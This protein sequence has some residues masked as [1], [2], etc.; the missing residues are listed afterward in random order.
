VLEAERT[1]LPETSGIRN[2]ANGAVTAL[3]FVGKWFQDDYYI[4][5]NEDGT[6]ERDIR[7]IRPFKWTVQ[8]KDL[9]I[10][11]PDSENIKWIMRYDIKGNKLILDDFGPNGA[12]SIGNESHWERADVVTKAPSKP[13][14]EVG[15][16]TTKPKYGVVEVN[17]KKDLTNLITPITNAVIKRD[18][19]SGKWMNLNDFNVNNLEYMSSGIDPKSLKE[20]VRNVGFDTEEY[21]TVIEFDALVRWE[22]KS[23]GKSIYQR[24]TAYVPVTVDT[25]EV[26]ADQVSN[27]F[28]NDANAAEEMKIIAWVKAQGQILKY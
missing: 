20:V 5:F 15:E 26:V 24:I 25:N 18:F 8:G 12:V 10:R 22:V 21:R 2:T 14:E 4:L 23:T 3:P 7:G 28:S 6:G 1:P 19:V 13:R 9:D 27:Y 16:T 17:T 11:W